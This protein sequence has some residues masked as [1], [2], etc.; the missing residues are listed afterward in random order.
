[1]EQV[2]KAHELD[3]M[4][5]RKLEAGHEDDV[6][7]AKSKVHRTFKQFQPIADDAT[8]NVAELATKLFPASAGGPSAK[9]RRTAKGEQ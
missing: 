5:E 2:Q 1:M 7:K 4:E 6:N 8:D 9:K 3:R